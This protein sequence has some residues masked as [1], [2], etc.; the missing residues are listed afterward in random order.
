MI[1]IA[2]I[3]FSKKEEDAMLKVLRSG[4]LVQNKEVEL[5][6][7]AF[8]KYNGV[9]YALATA[10]G[11]CALHLS[12]MSLN[13][14]KDDEVITTP[15]SFFASTSSI[16]YVGAKPV[17]VDIGPDFNIDISKIEKKITKKTRAILIVHLFGNSC[18]M[19]EILKLAKKHKLKVIADACQ[20]HGAEYRKKKIGN[21]GDLVCFSFHG[22][23]N[24]T[25]GEGGIITTNDKKLYEYLKM[26]RTHGSAIRYYHKFL[27]YNF[28][29]TEMQAALGRVQLEKLDDFNKKRAENASYYI[30]KLKN[31]K[32]LVLPQTA[33]YKKHVYQQFTVRITKEFPITRNQLCKLLD[34]KNIGYSIFY[35]L[36]IHKQEA[37]ESMGYKRES[38]PLSEKMSKEVI[39][40]PVYPLLAKKNLDFIITTLI[41]AGR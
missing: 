7:N 40:L 21:L 2:K 10:N 3:K 14:C 36:P 35:P 17:F 16:L 25:T 6:E 33:D 20:A 38:Y 24:M 8:A 19:D 5:F 27:G 41:E 15:F 39:S 34:K 29:M 18:E 23:K 37:L 32:G 28:R 13:L 1:P 11:T 31:I 12:L 22:T 9:K 4:Y 26:A 30:N